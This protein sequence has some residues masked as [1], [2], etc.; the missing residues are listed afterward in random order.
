MSVCVCVRVCVEK[1]HSVTGCIHSFDLRQTHSSLSLFR[2]TSDQSVDAAVKLSVPQT[3]DDLN[4]S[5]KRGR[6]VFEKR[7]VQERCEVS[8][9][10]RESRAQSL[11]P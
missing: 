10:G 2:L 7:C 1:T 11:L 6:L 9:D 4:R 8:E 5:S 3:P